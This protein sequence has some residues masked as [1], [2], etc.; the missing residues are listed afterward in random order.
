VI[1]NS[2]CQFAY[3]SAHADGPQDWASECPLH[4][5]GCSVADNPDQSPIDL[6]SSVGNAGNSYNVSFG[7][8]SIVFSDIETAATLV[9][10]QPVVYLEFDILE[11]L[12][13]LSSADDFLLLG[14]ITHAPSEHTIGGT[15]FALEFQ[16]VLSV[17][18]SSNAGFLVVSYLAQ[19]AGSSSPFVSN[20]SAVLS[21]I[22]SDST[23]I[24]Q[25]NFSL[26]LSALNNGQSFWG[27]E[28][29]LTVPPC[30]PTGWLVASTPLNVD[31]ADLASIVASPAVI[32]G[33]RPVFPS[34]GQAVVYYQPS[35]SP[36]NDGNWQVAVG[37]CAGLLGLM[38]IVIIV[39]AVLFRS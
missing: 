7:S 35:V 28:G 14:L 32:K 19:L 27:Y 22:Q 13:P 4:F 23:S 18:N 24:G 21:P 3:T 34:A 26:A 16:F 9:V 12:V 25:L 15:Q 36:A 6:P 37:V 2:N 17:A 8:A 38:L 30:E 5:S 11:A 39:G 10:D 31:Q 1:G 29:T 33:S 20:L